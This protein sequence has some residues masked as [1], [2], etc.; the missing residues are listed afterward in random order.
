MSTQ[1]NTYEQ[2]PSHRKALAI[3]VSAAIAGTG[4][5]TAQAD[6]LEEI[7]VTATKREASMQD[8]P[9]AVTAFSD[10]EIVREGFK[11][12]DDYIAEIPGLSQSDG[13]PGGTTLVMRGCA[14]S[15]TGYADNPTTSIYLDEQPI[16]SGGLNPDPRLV[17]VNRV[18]ALSGPQG[19]LFG[20]A[21]QCGTL[22]VI[23]NKPDAEEFDSWLDVTPVAAVEH[24]DFG[25]EA[26]GMVNIPLVEGKL[27]ARL[28]GFY[29]EEAGYIDNVLRPSV[30]MGIIAKDGGP[31]GG[32]FT[33]AAVAESDVNSSTTQGARA[34][35]RWTPSE[36]LTVDASAIW[37]D[38]QTDGFGDHDLNE[39]V[40]AT[41]GIGE[42]EQVR[43]GNDAWNDEWYQLSLTTEAKLSVADVTV[44]GSYMKREMRYDKDWTSY[45]A[46]GAVSNWY[47]P[48]AARYDWGNFGGGVRTAADT[49]A[50]AWDEVEQDQWTF[51]M[52]IATPD[53]LDS[54]WGGIVG[55]FYNNKD[56][57]EIW[58][59]DVYGQSD[60]CNGTGFNPGNTALG[61][62]YAHMY[63]QALSYAYT[64]AYQTPNDAWFTGKYHEILKEKAIFGE[65]SFDV[66]DKF[67]ITAGGRWYEQQQIRSVKNGFLIPVTSIDDTIDCNTQGC[68]ADSE[69]EKTQNGWVPK[70]NGT[71][72]YDDDRMIYFTYSEGFRRG[73]VNN[74]RF[75]A[76]AVGGANHHYNSDTLINYESGV[77]TTWLDNTLRVNITGYIM[78]WENIA[79]ETEDTTSGSFATGLVNLPEAR[80]KGLE[81]SVEWSPNDR[82]DMSAIVGWN[83]ARTSE[84]AMVFSTA[85]P[86][87]SILP[88]SPEIK[89]SVR[90][91]YTHPQRI[92]GAEPYAS[93]N[94]TYQGSSLSSLAG[95]TPASTGGKTRVQ[96]AYH[97]INL[98]AGLESESWTATVYLDNLFDERGKVFF[99]DSTSPTRVT[100]SQPRTVGLVVRKYFGK[101]W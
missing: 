98:H 70:V 56:E 55:F 47:A 45:L 40:F 64:G 25:Y 100:Y 50:Q 79:I 43:Y 9:M 67:T 99:N 75:G 69:F 60:N 84:A 31:S 65:I 54:R 97:T 26:N 1:N 83:K 4:T 35:L 81:G 11:Q 87:G 63:M 95:L 30:G 18:E 41:F 78:N 91:G 3:A 94:W 71:Y 76:F 34:G 93:G 12:L 66:T 72:Y 23:T 52:R 13:E 58:T 88:L 24:G 46:G 36:N 37:Q 59:A 17:D 48:Y 21:S 80:I 20:A 6:V 8:I 77:K 74:A 92:L 27:A 16:S 2:L 42:L 101:P 49:I 32:T 39:G 19:S 57:D 33:N 86:T 7:V 73:G 29:S 15:G 38:L 85:V 90:L 14:T 82:W 28:V 10:A 96:K 51:E 22:R 68:Y 89:S 44:T 53:D 61:C 5:N 62:S